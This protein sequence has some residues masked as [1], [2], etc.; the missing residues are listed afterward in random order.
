VAHDLMDRAV[1]STRLIPDVVLSDGDDAS[2][3]ATMLG[4][5]LEDNLRDFPSRARVAAR[6]R[7]PVAFRASDRDI[8]VTLSFGRGRVEIHNGAISGVPIVTGT[9]LAMANLCSGKLSPLRAVRSGEIEVH[10][11]R[12]LP[13]VAAV[14]YVLSVPASLY[15]RTRSDEPARHRRAGRATAVAIMLVAVFVVLTAA[16][17]LRRAREESSAR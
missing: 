16:Y 1:R 14:A 5:L 8:A 17:R 15:E 13:A 4:A 10:A 7:G 3:M 6:T 11:G 9:W 2:G 12:N